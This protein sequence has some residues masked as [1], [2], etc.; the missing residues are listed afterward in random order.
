DWIVMK[1]LEKDRDRRYESAAGL[2]RDVGR[3]LRDEPVQACP[4]SAGYRLRKFVRRNKGP[5]LAVSLLILSLLGGIIGTTLGV[6]NADPQRGLSEQNEVKAR[7]AGEAE[8]AAKQVALTRLDQIEK[9]DGILDSIFRGLDPY[10]EQK[11]G[12]TLREQMGDRL[13]LA[14]A[15]LKAE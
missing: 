11:G 12:P 8:R 3:Y 1:A 7:D 15:Q 13:Q 14:A 10:S 9:A 6:V 5:V 2:G 4:P